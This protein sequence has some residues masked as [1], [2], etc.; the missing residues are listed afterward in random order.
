MREAEATLGALE[1]NS[2]LHLLL[3]GLYREGGALA[4]ALREYRRACELLREYADR[5]SPRFIGPGL[6]PWLREVRPLL[7]GAALGDLRYLERA[8]AGGCS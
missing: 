5:H 4:P 8:L 2:Q 3:A 1:G 7:E 6:A